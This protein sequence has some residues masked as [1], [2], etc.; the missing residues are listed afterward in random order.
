MIE[1]KK[2]DLAFYEYYNYFAREKE[3]SFALFFVL[4][5][6]IWCLHYVGGK[7]KEVH[8]CDNLGVECQ[9]KGFRDYKKLFK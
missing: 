4:K 5:P 8:F 3:G 6:I 2:R 1:D 7:V 9:Y